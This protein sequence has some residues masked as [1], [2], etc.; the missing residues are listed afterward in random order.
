MTVFDVGRDSDIASLIGRAM[1]VITLIL[2][3]LFIS[4]KVSISKG[5][6]M[7][8][9]AFVGSLILITLAVIPLLSETSTDKLFIII[10]LAFLIGLPYIVNVFML[11]RDRYL[12]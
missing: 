10:S 3:I 6:V 8:L 2:S 5:L 4:K 1:P 9:N 12:D 7:T 11:F